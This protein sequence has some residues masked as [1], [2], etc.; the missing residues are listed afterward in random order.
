MARP[1]HHKRDAQ[2]AIVLALFSITPR[3]VIL[4]V[5]ER[6]A[7]VGGEHDERGLTEAGFFQRREDLAD[8][9]VEVLDHSHTQC[10]LLRDA[11]F[12][13][14]HFRQPLRRRLY[15]EMRS[16]VGQIEK[17][18]RQGFRALAQVVARPT[19]EN[20]RGVTDGRNDLAVAA[21]VIVP[22][23]E[24]RRVAV[25][26]VVEEAVEEVEAAVVGQ[27][28]RGEAEVPFADERGVIAGGAEVI[29]E[30]RHRGIEVAPGVV[31]IGADGPGHAD[32]VRVATAHERRARRRAH[33]GVGAHP[34]ESHPLGGPPTLPPACS[35][36]R[37]KPAPANFSPS[38]ARKNPV[39]P[40]CRFTAPCSA[41]AKTPT[42][43]PPNS[44][45]GPVAAAP[46]CNY[47]ASHEINGASRFE[48]RSAIFAPRSR[49]R[50]F[51]PV[52]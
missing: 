40:S 17:E 11:R 35:C 3:I 36:R 51:S 37:Q 5:G 10:A 49:P 38:S 43:S 4:R 30:R 33:G 12:S 39:C 13:L 41:F 20:L 32:A 42:T 31:G 29:G 8:A 52:Y 15:R 50:L 26:H 9:V 14:L 1:A 25:H 28:G 27:R 34:R 18:G 24:V 47:S 19:G 21:H 23:P 45:P 6:T 46:S 7:V 22:L 44:T 2:A 16:V 48:I